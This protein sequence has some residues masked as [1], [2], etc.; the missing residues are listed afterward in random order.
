MSIAVAVLLA[1]GLAFVWVRVVKTLTAPSDAPKAVGQPGALVWDG[2]VFSTPS[3]LKAYLGP[4][5][6]ARWSV[7][8]PTAFGAPAATAPRHATPTKTKTVKPKPVSEPVE[9]PAIS[10]SKSRSLAAI[11]LMILVMLGGLGLLA[12]ALV[13]TRLAPVALQRLYIED[14]DRRMIAFAAAT[15]ILLGFGVSLY[16]S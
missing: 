16:L 14:P 15:A 11:A 6:Y 10:A 3:Q 8:H 12:S 2:R 5:A 7:R 13:P 4:K 9:S 1:A